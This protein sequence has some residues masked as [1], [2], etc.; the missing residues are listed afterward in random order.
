MAVR[1]R[2]NA[3][4][5]LALGIVMAAD[6]ASCAE[7]GST[8]AQKQRS[9]PTATS[10]TRPV[11]SPP[12]VVSAPCRSTAVRFR[13]LGTQLGAGNDFGTIVLWNASAMPCRF[14]R[15]GSVTAIPG[16]GSGAMHF[17]LKHALS[18]PARSPQ[19]QVGGHLPQGVV[20][21][22]ITIRGEYRDGP[23]PN[24]LCSRPHEVVPRRWLLR[25]G[26]VRL[27]IPNGPREPIRQLPDGAHPYGGGGVQ[28]IESCGGGFSLGFAGRWA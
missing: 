22:A 6:G 1:I 21:F 19:P 12:T 5:R 13:Y 4:A 20:E 10:A 11:L 8:P 17:E 28:P 24:G 15:S 7:S 18:L 14:A 25:S 9:V 27:V 16:D 3:L 23:G 2:R 26:A